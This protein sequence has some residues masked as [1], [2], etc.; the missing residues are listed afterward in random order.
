M[1]SAFTRRWVARVRHTLMVL[2][3]TLTANSRSWCTLMYIPNTIIILHVR[4]VATLSGYHIL[5]NGLKF[6]LVVL[7]YSWYWGL[8]IL[9]ETTISATRWPIFWA[10]IYLFRLLYSNRVDNTFFPGPADTSDQIN[11]Q[12]WAHFRYNPRTK[13]RR[14]EPG[15]KAKYLVQNRRN[16]CQ[17]LLV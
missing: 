12:N 1:W 4:P 6:N 8:E 17:W 9:V 2:W 16:S 3:S 15:P 14:V 7:R 13:M 5:L 10:K 11:L